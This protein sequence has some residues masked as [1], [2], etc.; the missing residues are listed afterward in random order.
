MTEHQIYH[1]QGIARP[2]LSHIPFLS[3]SLVTLPRCLAAVHASFTFNPTATTRA[4]AAKEAGVEGRKERQR[5]RNDAGNVGVGVGSG[6]EIQ[7]RF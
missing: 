1:W 2:P 3:S 7:L 5:V 6:G 4:D